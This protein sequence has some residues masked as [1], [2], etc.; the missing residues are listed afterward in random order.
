MQD[1]KEMYYKLFSKV[2][3]VVEDLKEF[4]CQMEEM[5]VNNDTSDE[6]ENS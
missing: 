3:D 6:S 2:A 4:Q 5:Y 1:Y